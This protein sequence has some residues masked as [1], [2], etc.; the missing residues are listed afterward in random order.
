MVFLFVKSFLRRTISLSLSRARAHAQTLMHLCK[1]ISSVTS[2]LAFSLIIVL[3][4]EFLI[5]ILKTD[6]LHAE[7]PLKAL[8]QLGKNSWKLFFV[9][10][11]SFHPEVSMGMLFI[12]VYLWNQLFICWLLMVKYCLKLFLFILLVNTFPSIL[13]RQKS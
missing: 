1:F 6:S 8:Y 12:I 13:L 11:T 4:E 10:L 5:E 9:A 3:T 2:L 7:M